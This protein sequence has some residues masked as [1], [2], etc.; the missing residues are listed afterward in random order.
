M[1]TVSR[2]RVARSL[3]VRAGFGT[4]LHRLIV[5]RVSHLFLL[6]LS[7]LGEHQHSADSEGQCHHTNSANCPSIH[8]TILS[9]KTVDST[10]MTE[11]VISPQVN[12]TA[13]KEPA[14]DNPSRRFHSFRQTQH[15]ASQID[16][17]VSQRGNRN[18]R[19][20]KTDSVFMLRIRVDDGTP[21]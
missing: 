15:R 16:R 10:P 21:N 12:V 6:R 4:R 8:G 20:D 19:T 17:I 1:R 2:T 7:L 3:A 11:V 9:L 13:K 14:L 18:L 5:L